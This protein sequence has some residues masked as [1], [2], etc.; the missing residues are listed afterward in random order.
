MLD[1]A[2]VILN[3][4][5]PDLTIKC[6]KSILESDLNL[7]YKIWVVDNASTDNSL[8]KIS[9]FISQN[10]KLVFI[11]NT[12]NYGFSRGNNIAL[13]KVYKDTKYCL[14]LNSDTVVFKDSLSNLVNF[15]NN[16]DFEIASCKLLNPDN[17]LQPNTGSLPKP[18]AAYAWLSGLDDIF[19]KFIRI[20]SY[21]ERSK[22]YYLDEKEVGW[23][24][25]SVMLIKSFV[26]EKIGFFDEKI[27]MYGEDVDF[28]WRAKKKGCK[29]GWTNSAEILHIGGASSDKPKNTQWL[30]EFKGLLYLYEKHYD[31]FAQGLLKILIYFFILLRCISFFV[32]GK[33]EY[34]KTYAEIITNI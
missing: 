31:K 24:S 21:Q 12:K 27:F 33:K 4:N 7:S 23:V 14:L 16:N 11:K 18:F 29:I 10:S 34:A 6:L 28:C 1:L 22:S 26:F 9:K 32:L 2:I 30:G 17:S 8:E 20:Q 13:K 25:G 19:R 15:A 5:T 3:Y